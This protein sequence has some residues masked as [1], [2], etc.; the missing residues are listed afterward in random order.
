MRPHGRREPLRLDA[1]PV[2]RGLVPSRGLLAGGLA[3]L[4]VLGLAVALA[5]AGGGEK[6][7]GGEPEPP[8]MLAGAAFALRVPTGWAVDRRPRTLP[9]ARPGASV[10]LKNGDGSVRVVADRLPAVS[11]TLLP[12]T[13]TGTASRPETVSIGAGIRAWHY[14]GLSQPGL[15]DL[16]DVYLVPT[17]RGVITVACRTDAA[18]SLLAECWRAVAGLSLRGSQALA[19]GPAAAFRSALLPTMERLEDLRAEAQRRVMRAATR[20]EQADAVAPVAVAFQDAATRL[21]ALSTEGLPASLELPR[22]LRE[23]G[24]AWA[25]LERSLSRPGSAGVERAQA[26]LDARETRL[27]RQLV[28]ILDR[29][30]S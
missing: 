3:V 19:P 28:G 9:G 4:V 21:A 1:L 22:A 2:D 18:S 25:A 8:G 11:R 12:A 29:A 27:R 13:I 17:T 26:R 24:G 7:A 5:V 23:A 14:T 15:P 20:A 10:A 16:M 6:D 30:G